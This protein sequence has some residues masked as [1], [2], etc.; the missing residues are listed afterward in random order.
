[1]TSLFSRPATVSGSLIAGFATILALWLG[2]S[3]PAVSP[4]APAPTALSE[5]VASASTGVTDTPVAFVHHHHGH[6]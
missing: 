2:L 6:R 5:P 3:A 1:M 4:V